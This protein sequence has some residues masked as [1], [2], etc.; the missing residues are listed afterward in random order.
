V[1]QCVVQVLSFILIVCAIPSLLFPRQMWW[2]I[3]SGFFENPEEVE[4][5]AAAARTQRAMAI[6]AIL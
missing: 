5:S 6:C 4:P 1:L 3:N 2:W